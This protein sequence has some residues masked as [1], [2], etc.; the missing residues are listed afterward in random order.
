MSK[1]TKEKRQRNRQRKNRDETVKK[2]QQLDYQNV[3]LDVKGE[4]SDI[5]HD[6]NE[7]DSDKNV[8]KIISKPNSVTSKNIL[9]ESDDQNFGISVEIEVPLTEVEENLSHGNNQNDII[10]DSPYVDQRDLNEINQL[11]VISPRKQVKQSDNKGIKDC[12]ETKNDK[13]VDEIDRISLPSVTSKSSKSREVER[14]LDVEEFERVSLPS[15]KITSCEPVEVV[16]P[17]S[18]NQQPSQNLARKFSFGTLPNIT[19]KRNSFPTQPLKKPKVIKQ[20][21]KYAKSKQILEDN[22]KQMFL[23]DLPNEINDRD[24]EEQ[25][26]VSLTDIKNPNDLDIKN[27]TEQNLPVGDHSGNYRVPDSQLTNRP[28]RKGFT[29][30]IFVKVWNEI[31]TMNHYTK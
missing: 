13:T 7:P 29:C 22:P 11:K 9:P 8:Y 6:V 10:H 26:D 14:I 12:L 17:M 30:V 3:S 28:I 20:S 31:D 15:V 27:T 18:N 1:L 24:F 16:S 4:N 2:R 19:K 23:F 25:G 5:F 21:S